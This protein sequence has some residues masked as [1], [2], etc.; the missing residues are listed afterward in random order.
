MGVESVAVGEEIGKDWSQLQLKEGEMTGIK[1][2]R[3]KRRKKTD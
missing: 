2:S 3:E 1:R